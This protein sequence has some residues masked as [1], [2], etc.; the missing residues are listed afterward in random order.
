MQ[1]AVNK[2]FTFILFQKFQRFFD[3]SRKHCFIADLDDRP[4]DQIWM[5]DHRRDNHVVRRF[6]REAERFEF[7]L[8]LS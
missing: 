4:L 6:K 1:M 3:R 2:N 5:L 8:T 7:R